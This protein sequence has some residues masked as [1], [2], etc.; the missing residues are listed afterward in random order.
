MIDGIK[1]SIDPE[2]VRCS[3]ILEFKPFGNRMRAKYKSLIIDLYEHSCHV[4]GSIHKYSN[5]GRHNK[6]DFLLSKF[7]ETLYDLCLTLDIRPES[8]LFHS[9][10]FGV[11]IQIPCN[12]N[13]FI[14]SIVFFRNGII[15]KTDLGIEIQL[16][17][18]KLKMYRKEFDGMDLLRVEVAIRKKRRVKTITQA[19]V[20]HTQTLDDLVNSK[21]WEAFGNELLTAYDDILIVDVDSIDYKKLDKRELDL[22][23][24]G[25]TSDYWIKEWTNRTQRSYYLKKFKELLAK[26]STRNIKDEVRALIS[27]KINDLIDIESEPIYTPEFAIKVNGKPYAFTNG[28]F[29]ETN[30]KPYAFTL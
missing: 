21:L 11:N 4:R 29:K 24:K 6:D 22:W 25:K 20:S 27:D 16:S 7:I 5:D 13:D 19:Y 8:S 1:F 23:I 28:G 30:Q 9:V 14:N 2:A 3:D 10:E 18:Y 15:N 12:V 26:H 17:E